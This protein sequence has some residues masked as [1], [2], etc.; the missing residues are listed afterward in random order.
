MNL[1]KFFNQTAVY[2][3]NPQPDGWGGFTYDDP[4]EVLVRWTDKVERFLPAGYGTGKQ[5]IEEMLSRTVLLSETDFDINGRVFLGELTDLD[6]DQDPDGVGALTIKGH[7]KI[8]DLKAQQ[9]LRK[10]WL[11]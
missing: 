9:F 7:A 5:M 10:T 3:G 2:W 6:S 4:V 11:V 8:P 1:S